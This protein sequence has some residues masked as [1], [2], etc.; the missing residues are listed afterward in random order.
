MVDAGCRTLEPYGDCRAFGMNTLSLATGP[1]GH[2][3]ILLRSTPDFCCKGSEKS[4]LYL[5]GKFWFCWELAFFK[6][7]TNL[8]MSQ[9]AY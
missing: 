6:N 7:N 1:W 2:S 9:E 5:L 3:P 8:R 4:H